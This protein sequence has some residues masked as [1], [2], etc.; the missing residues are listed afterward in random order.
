MTKQTG[1]PESIID[2]KQFVAMCQIQCTMAEICG[3]LDVDEK[4]LT[5]WCKATF[6]MSFSQ[7]YRQKKQGGKVSLRRMQWKNAEGGNVT[8]QIFLGKNYLGQRDK[9]EDLDGDTNKD[10]SKKVIYTVAE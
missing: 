6:N 7:I 3:I 10:A 8:M 1:R 9:P 4:T 5:K 2:E